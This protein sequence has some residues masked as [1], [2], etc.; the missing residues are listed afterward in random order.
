MNYLRVFE[1]KIPVHKEAQYENRL[2]RLNNEKQSICSKAN[3]TGKIVK[4]CTAE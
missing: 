2:N 4:R 1:S 3:L